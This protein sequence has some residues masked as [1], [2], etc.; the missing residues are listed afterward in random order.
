VAAASAVVRGG[1]GEAK[2]VERWYR[3]QCVFRLRVAM[4]AT[5]LHKVGRRQDGGRRRAQCAGRVS[6]PRIHDWAPSVVPGTP[7]TR[8]NPRNGIYV[9]G[10]YASVPRLLPLL[11]PRHLVPLPFSFTPIFS[12]PLPRSP[13]PP[14]P[15]PSSS[16]PPILLDLS[17][18]ATRLS[19]CSSSLCFLLFSLPRH[20]AERAPP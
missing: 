6:N 13:S 10:R 5:A 9:G 18:S 12:G 8:Q 19:F 7:R 4:R 11:L 1:G 17:C 16:L 14:P 2:L 20:A 3:G 15:P